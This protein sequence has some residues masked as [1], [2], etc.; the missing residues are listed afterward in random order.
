[1]DN[2]YFEDSNFGYQWLFSQFCSKIPAPGRAR[3]LEKVSIR[4]L[5]YSA[6]RLAV[7]QHKLISFVRSIQT[8]KCSR[9]NLT[10]ENMKMLKNE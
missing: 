3:R 5:T 7:P 4:N 6:D 8:L 9:S 2:V 1:M 10:K